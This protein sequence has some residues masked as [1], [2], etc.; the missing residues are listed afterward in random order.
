MLSARRDSASTS[1]R[2]A[3]PG[4]KLTVGTLDDLRQAAKGGQDPDPDSEWL[5]LGL[6]AATALFFV[7]FVVQPHNEH[8][9]LQRTCR[10]AKIIGAKPVLLSGCWYRCPDTVSL[11]PGM[12]C[13]MLLLSCLML[14]QGA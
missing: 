12:V 11:V 1:C 6:C 5:G 8:C 3:A 14:L 2:R 4:I 9:K 10:I 13:F 7:C